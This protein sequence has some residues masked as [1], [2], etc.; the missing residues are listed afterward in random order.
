MKLL[1]FEEE[2]LAISRLRSAIKDL[3]VAENQI[4]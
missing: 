4:R 3:K 1:D 2:A